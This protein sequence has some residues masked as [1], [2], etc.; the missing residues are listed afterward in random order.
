MTKTPRKEEDSNMYIQA[1]FK[2]P[3]VYRAE[4]SSSR[5]REVE[6]HAGNDRI[7][8]LEVLLLTQF[9]KKKKQLDLGSFVVKYPVLGEQ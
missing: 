9:T 5:P 2:S 7:V 3:L 8:V 1:D 4:F 6:N